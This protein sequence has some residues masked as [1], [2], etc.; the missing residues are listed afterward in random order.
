MKNL[1]I[2]TF[3][4]AK[5]INRVYE[6]ERLNVYNN[7][8]NQ[9]YVI[10]NHDSKIFSNYNTISLDMED[11]YQNL[12]F[13][14]VKLLEYFLDSK[15]DYCLK[16]DDDSFVDINRLCKFEYNSLD[17]AGLFFN[18]NVN[19]PIEYFKKIEYTQEFLDVKSFSFCAGGGYFLSKKSAEKIVTNYKKSV[20]YQRYLFYGM[21]SEDRMVGDLLYSEKLNTFN[22]GIVYSDKPDYSIIFNSIYHPIDVD[23]MVKLKH[24][25]LI[26]KIIRERKF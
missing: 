26:H 15:Y 8:S 21:A 25:S 14:T 13:K 3:S 4:C 7:I 18:T 22:N 10:T 12:I 5:N 23:I 20:E 16:C 6:L 2:G 17:Y 1:L 24:K 9:Y 11:G 19:F